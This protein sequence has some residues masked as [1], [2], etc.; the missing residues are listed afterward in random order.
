MAALPDPAPEIER[1]LAAV[2]GL[3]RR[4]REYELQVTE[5]VEE[6]P[7]DATWPGEE[8][9]RRILGDQSADAD[10]RFAAFFLLGT[11]YRRSTRARDLQE[12]LA[13]QA[14]L[15]RELLY[16]HLEVL[17]LN[18]L[19]GRER[20]L[21][22]LELARQLRAESPDHAGICHSYAENVA[23]CVLHEYVEPD[24]TRLQDALA[25][26][27]TAVQAEKR[28]KFYR[29]QGWLQFLTGTPEAGRASFGQAMELENRRAK[30]YVLRLLDH[31]RLL[32]T[33]EANERLRALRE[34]EASLEA[35]LASLLGSVGGQQAKVT[36]LTDSIGELQ[37]TVEGVRDRNLEFM[38]FFAALLALILG[39]LSEVKN[40]DLFEGTL[41]TVALGGVLLLAFGGL[42]AL[43]RDGWR[44]SRNGALVL[45]GAVMVLTALLLPKGCPQPAAQS[46]GAAAPPEAADPTASPS[47]SAPAARPAPP[48]A[49][50]PPAA[51]Q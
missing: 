47:P 9:L 48:A 43:L 33:L 35:R 40:H 26:A 10:R 45:L 31:R 8:A 5:H 41:L 34:N 22:A 32:D 23:N 14:Q 16:R 11:L 7:L 28:A 21:Q 42:G 25:A 3:D 15:G 39:T 38:G 20:C 27:E 50:R 19:G 29:T 36:A 49:A 37:K 51:N 24:A 13:G 17:E 2:S 6:L 12:L 4:R 46:S 1:F 18:L 44:W 30:D